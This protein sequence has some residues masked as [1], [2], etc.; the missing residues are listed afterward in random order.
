MCFAFSQECQ[1]II[2]LRSLNSGTDVAALARE[3]V[4]KCSLIHHSKLA[5]VEQLIFYLKQ[6]NSRSTNSESGNTDTPTETAS[7]AKL[8]DYVELLYENIPDKVMCT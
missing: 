8:E 1:K 3:V 2:R 5:E 7:I 4:E 6:R